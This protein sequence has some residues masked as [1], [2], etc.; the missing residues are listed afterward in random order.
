[1]A[2]KSSDAL[3][4]WH[5]SSGARPL[6]VLL[7]QARPLQQ[8]RVLRVTGKKRFLWARDCFYFYWLSPRAK[9]TIFFFL[10]NIPSQPIS[11]TKLSLP[12]P[13]RLYSYLTSKYT[14]ASLKTLVL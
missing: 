9:L 10:T 3:V 12:T 11:P 8:P 14:L 13:K 6:V 2:I 4:W 7:I 5:G 1:M